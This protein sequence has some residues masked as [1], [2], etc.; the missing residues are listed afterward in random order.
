[1]IEF[2]IKPLTKR[3]TDALNQ[4]F[5]A[6][7]NFTIPMKQSGVHMLRETDKNFRAAKSPDNKK[8]KPLSP[9]TPLGR[10]KAGGAR[11]LQDTGLLKNSVTFK[12]VGSNK[13]IIWAVRKS[14]G[15]DLAAVHQFG[16]TIKP[17]TKKW[18]TVPISKLVR[19]TTAGELHRQKKTFI[20]TSKKG[21]PIIML[22]T[23]GGKAIP[24]YYLTKKVEIPARPFLGFS[25]ENIEDIEKI[26][27]L[28][29][30]KVLKTK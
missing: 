29:A 3:V 8:W 17:K 22:K 10:V 4:D 19:L 6:F 21:T 26:F 15:R 11:P 28:H 5:K 20:I 9:I 14:G 27:S 1:M 7:G 30:K 2:D 23:T 18:L 12:P 16:A 25:K 24:V 13:I